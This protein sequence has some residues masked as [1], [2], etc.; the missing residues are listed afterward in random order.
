[1]PPKQKPKMASLFKTMTL[2]HITVADALKLL[3]LPRVIGADPNDG[4]DVTA[5]NGRYGP[6]ISKGKE[7][8]SLDNEE[9]IFTVTLDE[10]LN[11]LAQPKKYGRRQAAPPLRD[12]GADPDTGKGMVVKEGR[13][14]PY[15]TD[16]ETNASIPKSLLVETLTPE[17]ASE[18]LRDRRERGPAEPKK[19]APA[20]KAAAKKKASAKK[21]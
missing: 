12:L 9:R 2:E 20:K 3:S 1:L 17:Q 10:A 18:L 8:R 5:Q 4:E 14:G 19:K 13:F 7:T 6:Y 21:A 15:V 11:L 16:G